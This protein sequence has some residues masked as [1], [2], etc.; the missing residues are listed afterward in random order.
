LKNIISS[1]IHFF[2]NSHYT[3]E[4]L[5]KNSTLLTRS[6][7]DDRVYKIEQERSDLQRSLV[8]TSSQFDQLASEKLGLTVALD[9]L[10]RKM[11]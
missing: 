8:Q 10:R 9:E 4:Q 1:F 6:L 5:N 11:N 7:N 2:L 3:R